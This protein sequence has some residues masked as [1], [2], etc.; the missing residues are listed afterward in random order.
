MVT[1]K[2]I[3]D[4]KSPRMF[5]NTNPKECSLEELSK[6]KEETEKEKG[7]ETYI[8]L[9]GLAYTFAKTLPL[10]GRRI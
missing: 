4:F 8:N 3:D 9:L 7:I 5:I 1:V 6:P 10:L 2:D